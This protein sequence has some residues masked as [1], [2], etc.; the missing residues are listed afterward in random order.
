MFSLT[1]H[2]FRDSF[3][4]NTGRY[5]GRDSDSGTADTAARGTDRREEVGTNA[6]GLQTPLNMV[7]SGLDP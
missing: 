3:H 5:T 6:L 1:V 7:H 2:F 4:D